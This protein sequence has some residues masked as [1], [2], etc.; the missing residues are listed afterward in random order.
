MHMYYKDLVESGVD[1]KSKPYANVSQ[2]DWE[3]IIETLYKDPK[4][5]VIFISYAN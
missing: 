5:Q 3:Y 1:P 4:F 2:E